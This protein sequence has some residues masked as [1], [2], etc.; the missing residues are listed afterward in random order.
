MDNGQLSLL[1]F[2][3]EQVEDSK[4]GRLEIINA[5]FI[6]TDNVSWRELFEGF[7]SLYG[8]TYSSGIYFMEKVMDMFSHVE[9][10]FGCEVTVSDEIAAILSFQTASIEQI[11]KS[12]SAKRIA[13]RMEA[14]EMILSVSRDMKSHEKIFIL[15]A[16]DGRTRVITGSANM[17]ASAF[18]GHQRENIVCFDDLEAYEYYKSLFDDFQMTCSDNV[19]YEVIL[20]TKDDSDFIRDNVEEIPILKTIEKKS[21]VI[22]EPAEDDRQEIDIL[23][24]IKGL[25]AEMKPL[26]PKM[27][28]DNGKYILT[29]EFK[30]AFKRQCKEYAE[31]KKEKVKVLPKLHIDYRYSNTA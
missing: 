13:E 28:K 25:E 3:P 2:V 24:D 26:L 29:G 19:N 14:E 4:S 9:M 27:K 12:K 1:D 17:S 8:I 6:S 20:A 23:A 31:V 16:N 11:V 18:C 5:N 21:M 30:K 22:L 7:D 10:I 15:K